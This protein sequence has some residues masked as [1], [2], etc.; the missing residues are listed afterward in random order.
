MHKNGGYSQK[1]GEVALLINNNLIIERRYDLDIAKGIGIILVVWAHANGPL[2]D[3]IGQFHMPLFF[4]I[5]GMLFHDNGNLFPYIKRK[6]NSLLLPFWR[7]N[8][9]LYPLFYI[10]YYWKQWSFQVLIIG[11][12]EIILTVNKVPFLGATWFLPA[13]SYFAWGYSGSW[14]CR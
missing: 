10:L 8:L 5:S 1:Q 4:F 12:T 2:T 6:C 3:I 11:I 7:W 13:L 14:I 9:M